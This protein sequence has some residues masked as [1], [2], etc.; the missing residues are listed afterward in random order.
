MSRPLTVALS[1]NSAFGVANF[2]TGIIRA[3]LAEGHRVVV[4]ARSDEYTPAIRALGAEFFDW[5]VSGRS[6]GPGAELRSIAAL[7]AIYREVRPDL[8][9]HFTI[10]AVIYGAIAGKLLGIPFISLITGLG[11]VFLNDTWASRVSRALY[12]RTLRWSR[13]VWFL[14]DEDRLTFERLNLLRPAQARMLPGEGIDMEYF[15][16]AMR[17]RDPAEPPAFLMIARLLRDKGVYEYID[18]AR[19]VHASGRPARFLL[20]GAADAD[21]PSAIGRAQV[22]EWHREGVIEYLGTTPD[23]R[24]SIRSADCVVLPSYREGAPRVLLEAAS[25]ER[26]VV[27]TDVPGCRD[28]VVDAQ[29][30]FLCKARNAADLA[31]QM[32]CIM[33]LDP[34]RLRTMGRK[35]RELVAERYDERIVIEHYRHAL[36]RLTAGASPI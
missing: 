24:P 34:E 31:R 26:P 17:E 9:F 19:I 2:R 29:T 18:A 14:N 12:R 11:Y 32:M 36:E 27:T 15:A 16:A 35:A 6:T 30:G 25:M 8:A 21:N 5:Q 3:I 13:E 33:D 28:M 10:K 1:C 7:I 22:D 20:L 23:V 4:V